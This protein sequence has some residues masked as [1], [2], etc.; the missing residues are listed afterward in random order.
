MTVP[1]GLDHLVFAVPDLARG[2]EDFATR[3][4]VR[5]SP[6]GPHPGLGTRNFLL[7]LADA[8]Y[9]EIIGPDPEQETP[10]RPRPFG[11]DQLERGTLATWAVHV[12]DIDRRVA[13]ARQ[14]GFDPGVVLPLSRQSP[15]GLIE[16]K[17]TMRPD[18]AA[19]GLVPF[20]IDWGK[21]PNPATTSAKG[22]SLVALRAEHPE[23]DRVRELLA[24]LGVTLD[25]GRAKAPAL[26][27]TLATPKGTVELR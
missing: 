1:A 21:T 11:I 4:G 23:P 13:S 17:L 5:P 3:V 8:S 16:W 20:L 22:C 25:V 10:P 14:A 9:L 7:S 15:A 2:V 6:G 27:A 26:V 19:D 18:R 12:D 24:A